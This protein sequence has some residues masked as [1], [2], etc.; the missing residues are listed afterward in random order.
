MSLLQKA[1]IWASLVDQVKIST[2]NAWELGSILGSGRS[3]EKDMTT[4]SSILAWRIPMDRRAWWASVHGVAKS[5]TSQI[6]VTDTDNG[7]QL[8]VRKITLSFLYDFLALSYVINKQN[9]CM[10]LLIEPNK[11]HA[12]NDTLELTDTNVLKI[13]LGI[14]NSCLLPRHSIVIKFIIHM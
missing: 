10:L 5:Q 4:H 7:E 6:R 9:L 14:L 2:C 11:T 12:F 1:P 8:N 13:I 3:L